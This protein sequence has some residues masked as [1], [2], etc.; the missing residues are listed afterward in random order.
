[1]KADK[2]SIQDKVKSKITDL[3]T[4][5]TLTQAEADKVIEYFQKELPR[6]RN[7]EDRI[8]P[9]EQLVKDGVLTQEKMEALAKEIPMRKPSPKGQ[10]LPPKADL[11]S[12]VSTGVLTQAEAD[13]VKEYLET[14]RLQKGLTIGDRISPFE[15]M[16]KD[17]VLTQEKADAIAK[18]MPKTIHKRGHGP[19]VKDQTTDEQSVEI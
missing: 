7:I 11:S 16:V 19:M 13:K 9:L 14:F 4:A 15:Q 8:N 12:L 5:G 3:V 18:A 17:G 2:A 6:D 1:M 10:S